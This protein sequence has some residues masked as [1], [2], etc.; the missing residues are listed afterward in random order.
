M[1]IRAEELFSKDIINI[2]DGM[3]V[4][5]VDDLEIDTIKAEVKSLVVFGRRR[6]FGLL[7][8]DEDIVLKWDDI[9][10][11]GEDVILVN[12]PFTPTGRKKRKYLDN[13][14]K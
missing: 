7:G 12:L 9:N 14:F 6:M 3:R 10:I 2:K 1:I 11:I 8:R 13:L 4:G 5:S